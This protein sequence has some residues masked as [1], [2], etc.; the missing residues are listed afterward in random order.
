MGIISQF[1][2]LM[3]LR[4]AFDQSTNYMTWAVLTLIT[5]YV[6][7][8]IFQL[9]HFKHKFSVPVSLFLFLLS[10]LI[11]IFNLF[12]M[13]VVFQQKLGSVVGVIS[14]LIGFIIIFINSAPVLF[15]LAPF[16]K[17]PVKE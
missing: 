5:A 3:T 12:L 15:S 1:P 17:K 16:A 7:L 6:G 14:F 8:T 13:A 2:F 11:C 9:P 4:E 10:A